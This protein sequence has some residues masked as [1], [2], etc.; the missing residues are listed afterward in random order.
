MDD[1][2]FCYLVFLSIC[3]FWVLVPY[4]VTIFSH[5]LG[6]LLILVTVSIDVQKLYNLMQFHQIKFLLLFPG[7]L[8]SYSENNYLYLYHPEFSLFFTV[9]QSFR[10]YIK[11]FDDHS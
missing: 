7:Q 9:F 2:L 5:S 6:C 11:I 3:M 4:L 8:E 1:L 10:S